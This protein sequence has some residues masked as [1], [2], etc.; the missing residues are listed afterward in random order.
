LILYPQGAGK[1]AHVQLSLPIDQNFIITFS[2]VTDKRENFS[3]VV[4][5]LYDSDLMG[6]VENG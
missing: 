2:M 3:L 4:N 5:I 6:D 1:N